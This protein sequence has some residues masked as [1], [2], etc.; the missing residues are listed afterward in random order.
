MSLAALPP[1][2]PTR[3]FDVKIKRCIK[4]GQ[5]KVGC[6]PPEDFYIDP[7]S[8]KVDEK[9]G[10]FYA[11]KFRITR[12]D[13]KL[14]W[15]K[16]KELIDELPAYTSTEDEG[17]KQSRNSRFW[18]FQQRETDKATEEIEVFECYVNVDYDGD[19]VAEWRQICVG[20]LAGGRQIISNTEW[21]GDLPYVSITPDPMPHRYRGRSV[22]DEVG[23]IQRVK[24][25]LLRQ[26]MDNNYVVNNPM[27]AANGTSIENRDALTNPEI[28]QIVWTN[29]DPGASMMPVQVPY[30]GDKIFPISRIL[31]HGHREE[32]RCV[33]LHHGPRPRY[34]PASDSHSRQRAA[35]RSLHKSGNIRAKYLRVWR[36]QRA[37]HKFLK[38]FVQNQKSVKHIKS[39]GQWVALDPRGWQADMKVTINVGLGAGSRD[40]D[41]AMLGGIAQK[42]EIA[43]QALQSPFNPILNVGHIFDTYR[44]MVETGG[45]KSPEN[46]FPELTQEK[47]SELG[48][49]FSQSQQPPPEMIKMQIEQQKMQ[50]DQQ[51]RGMELQAEQQRDQNR[52][53]LDQKAFEQK[54]AIEA[55]QA[56]ADVATTNTKMQADVQTNQ[57]KV[58]ADIEMN[59]QKLMMEA[60][61]EE[62]RFQLEEKLKMMEYRLKVGLEKAKL[63]STGGKQ[64]TNPETGQTTGP[65]PDAIQAALAQLDSLS[66]P[67]PI[68]QQD[69]RSDQMTA[70]MTALTQ[71][72][73]QLA[74]AHMAPSQVIRDPTT[75]RIIGAQKRLLELTWPHSRYSTRPSTTSVS[76]GSICDTDI[77]K[78]MLTTAAPIQGTWAIKT[79]VTGEIAATGGYT[80]GGLALTGV[81]WVETGAGLG[82]WRFQL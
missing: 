19:G 25:V 64:T 17:V 77:F 53:M 35:I 82:V 9:E 8:T 71:A 69:V 76:S 28:G 18:S 39:R 5:L 2:P 33:P 26:L 11:D 23:D 48:Q 6:L 16:K 58:Q 68:K 10:R 65:D 43:I 15:P 70:V 56:Q 1:P 24:S 3:L 50:A 78:A 60:Q 59:R 75:N 31:G 55:T 52:A 61:M 73:Q 51:M 74:H 38:L 7:N 22:Y 49:Q 12:S 72:M 34:P 20:G 62:R 57:Q 13:A 29:G 45:L 32:N 46:Y 40:R 63:I 44:R 14:R 42:Q 81:D 30:V 36:V 80:T 79:D 27:I 41:M 67:E 37:I 47:V 21:G 66:I 4:S 54:A